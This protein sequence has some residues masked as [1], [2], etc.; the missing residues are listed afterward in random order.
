WFCTSPFD[1]YALR[2]VAAAQL[3]TTSN[4]QGWATVPGSWTWFEW[5]IFANAEEA[6]R[7]A[8]EKYKSQRWTT[9]H[10]NL[11][12]ESKPQELSGPVVTVD[13]DMWKGFAE[14]SVLAVRI[15]ALTIYWECFAHRAEIKFWRWFEPVIDL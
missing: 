6:A 1:D 15:C 11:R 12:A 13:N 2:H 5:G 10:R 4:D 9:S 3:L 8:K 14:G 7:L